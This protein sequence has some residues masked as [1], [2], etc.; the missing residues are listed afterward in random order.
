MKSIYVIILGVVLLIATFFRFYNLNTVPPS[1]SLD[2]VS[3]GWNAYSIFQTG[4][5]EYGYKLPILLRAYDDWRP[6]LYVYFVAPFVKIFGLEVLS[7]RLPSVI[8]SVITILTTYL[9]VKELFRNQKI[10]N[11]E[12]IALVSAFFLA[13]SPWHIYISRLGHEVNLGLSFMILGLLFFFKKRIYLSGAFFVLSFISYQTEKIFIPLLL[14]GI[15]FIYRSDIL[16][17]KKKIAIAAL[18]S[19]L[20]L[21][22]FIFASLSE[23]ALIRFS[24]TNVFEANEHRFIEQSQLLHKAVTENDFLGQLL[25]NRRILM[26]QIFI[27]GYLS[28]FNPVWLFTNA[29]ED[30]HK[31]PNLGL[32]YP[33]EIP[34][35]LIGI[36]ILIRNNF[37]L[38]VKMTIF[39]W[40]LISP[41]AAAITTDAPHAVRSF[42]FLPTWQIFSSLGIVTAFYYLKKEGLRRLFLTIGVLIV[43][44]S[45]LYLYKQY[46]FIFPQKQSE[47]FQ[48]G[49]YQ[50]ISFVNENGKN[51][52]KVI[53]TNHDR[54]AQSYMFF[55]FFNKY[56]PKIYQ[57]QGGTASGGYDK[58]HS[59]GKY[60]FRKL[61][62]LKEKRGNLYIGNFHDFPTSSK[63]LKSFRTLKIISD[64]SGKKI[65]RI[66]TK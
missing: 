21:I 30:R 48:Y 15:F 2:E 49:L 6:A 22:P 66:V 17:I 14:I 50:A 61:D 51:Y 5:D 56:D 20:V 29:S 12:I 10:L 34:F 4:K 39:I 63:D 53:F 57:E 26:G 59:F 35:I 18:F 3:L 19:L 1:A 41:V 62:I 33:W 13:I 7:V 60:E 58:A 11:Y 44:I 27:E 31:I 65:I 52:K 25:Y 55:L 8:L 46:F 43:I 42:I 47:S 64:S 54:L 28:H 16:K 23:D 24:G 45:I 40:F 9:L 36:Y 38:K 32:L 37:D